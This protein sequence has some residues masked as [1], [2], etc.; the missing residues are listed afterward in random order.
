MTAQMI[1]NGIY[2]SA[3]NEIESSYEGAG[4][5]GAPAKEVALRKYFFL[6]K[7]GVML[8]KNILG[9]DCPAMGPIQETPNPG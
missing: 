3:R 2:R 6:G 7:Y 9:A 5:L 1:V 8:A 4:P